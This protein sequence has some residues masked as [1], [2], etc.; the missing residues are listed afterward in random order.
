MHRQRLSNEN[1]LRTLHFKET[2]LSCGPAPWAHTCV[3][4][5]CVARAVTR[6]LDTE[7]A[8]VCWAAGQLRHG[9]WLV[10]IDGM[11]AYLGCIGLIDQSELSG[12]RHS[13]P[14]QVLHSTAHLLLDCQL[15][16]LSPGAG[17]PSE[18]AGTQVGDAAASPAQ[19]HY[20]RVPPLT[21]PAFCLSAFCA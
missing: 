9:R 2:I 10:M 3:Q 11:E 19:G 12:H 5:V 13:Q 15:A 18:M 14:H 7:G 20:K 1:Q 17:L 8:E 6:Q 21:K 16:Q 4:L